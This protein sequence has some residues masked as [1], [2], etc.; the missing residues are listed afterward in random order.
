MALNS[1]KY[2]IGFFKHNPNQY[3]N[4]SV[5]SLLKVARFKS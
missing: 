4:N 5:S 1:Q 3:L 2:Q